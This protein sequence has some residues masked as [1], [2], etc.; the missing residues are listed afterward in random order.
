MREQKYRAVIT[1]H[2]TVITFAL[3][4]LVNL[5]PLFSIRELVIPWLQAGNK[6]DDYAGLKDKNG[7]EIYEGDIVRDCN[8]NVLQVSWAN[9]WARYMMS[10]DGER[11]IY[12][13]EDY[14]NNKPDCLSMNMTVIGN[15]Y[16]NPE[17]L[18]G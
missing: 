1:P 17:L 12:Y 14:K 6:P 2:K 3:S 13:L 16:E 9:C 5:K 4:D 7:V 10:F 18:K 15:I 8:N 11:C